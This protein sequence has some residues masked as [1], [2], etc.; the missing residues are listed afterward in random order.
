[1]S[2]LIGLARQEAMQLW[3]PVSRLR[4]VCPVLLAAF[5]S[6][7]AAA[8]A[9][10]VTTRTLNADGGWCWFQDERALIAGSN[11]VFA[12]ISSSGTVTVTSYDTASSG[13]TVVFIK[14]N[15]V[16]PGG[17]PDDHNVAALLHRNDGRFVAFY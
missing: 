4:Q 10:D 13:S 8:S 14:S 12:S 6:F 9:T 5:V 15:F 16:Q 17:L 2:R 3:Q 11:L 7:S 1:M